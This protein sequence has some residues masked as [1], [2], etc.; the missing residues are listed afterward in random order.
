MHVRFALALVL[1]LAIHTAPA[2]AADDASA[3]VLSRTSLGPLVLGKDA[4]VSQKSLQKLFPGYTV[5]YEIAQGDSPD[6]HYF[7]VID[8]NGELLFAISSF[9]DDDEDGTIQHQKTTSPVPIQLL[10]VYSP[11][12]SDAYGLHVGDHVKDIIAKR[13]KKLAFGAAHHDVYLGAGEIYYSIET[14]S[15]ESPENFKLKDAIKGDWQIHSL[16]WPGAAW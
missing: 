14:G 15:D 12:I 13:G 11:T 9:I 3:L 2:M 8:K 4:K 5:K 6:F 1:A 7:E 16:S 10:Q